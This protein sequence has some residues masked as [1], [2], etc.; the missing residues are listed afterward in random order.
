MSRAESRRR[1]ELLAEKRFV[2]TWQHSSK[3]RHHSLRLEYAF[4]E[5]QG[6][7]QRARTSASAS[8]GK[9]RQDTHNASREQS[10][11]SEAGRGDRLGMVEF[12][13][14]IM[15]CRQSDRNAGQ[16]HYSTEQDKQTM[17]GI[18]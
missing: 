7:T 14:G 5:Q 10:L 8:R 16:G 3:N 18:E 11:I 2:S 12:A 15:A 17:Q 13:Q 6:A 4:K 1:L 9:P